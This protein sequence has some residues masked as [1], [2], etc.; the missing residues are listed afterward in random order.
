M[1]PTETNSAESE[2]SAELF[3]EAAEFV[4][5]A[6]E[7][8][9][10]HAECGTSGF[11][12]GEPK[13]AARP[14]DSAHAASAPVAA[15]HPAPAAF[16][17]PAPASF[18]AGQDAHSAHHAHEAQPAPEQRPTFAMPTFEAPAAAPKVAA[19]L[20]VLSNE[21]RRAKLQLID[22]RV[23][24]CVACGLH[25]GRSQT[26]FSRGDPSAE[27]CFVGEGP[28]ADED[29]EGLPFVGK[30]GQLLDKMIQAMGLGPNDV[31]I[32]NVVKCRPPENRTPEA[33]EMATCLPYLQEQLEVV[34]PK[35]IV[36]LGSTALKGLMGPSEGI[37]KARGSW[38]LF[39]G[40]IPLMPTFHPA[41]VLRQ[42]TREIKGMVWSDLQQVLKHLGRSPKA[43]G[44]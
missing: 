9:W 25:Q 35:V 28:G 15:H 5:A 13:R 3:D 34:T 8:V 11:P 44:V 22:Q 21:E 20:V 26:V 23:K 37:T 43:G 16:N 33:S 19:P 14:V 18:N 32:C 24:A 30:A 12:R 41:Y 36:A 1:T 40:K 38:R 7:F 31:Y 42:P 2:D 4:R 10:W 29:R 39:R 17:A 27:L 6:R